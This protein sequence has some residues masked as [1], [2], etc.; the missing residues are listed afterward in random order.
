MRLGCML[1]IILIVLSACQAPNI[2][3]REI[4]MYDGGGDMVGTA[5]FIDQ[6][7]GV[8]IKVK[9]EG[10]DPGFHGAH[11][12]EFPICEGPDFTSAG[13]HFNPEGNKHGLMHPDGAHLGDLPNIEADDAG[14]AEAELLA[15]EA[16]LLEGKNSFLKGDG[17]SFIITANQDDGVSQPG[18]DSGKRL[19]CGKLTNE[20]KSEQK[21][22]SPTDPTEIEGEDEEE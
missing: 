22:N 11:V 16:T 1:G 15:P 19:L 12:H 6:E 21:E 5:T 20:Q 3:L 18:G 4:D 2:S 10:L 8:K 17:V 13:N 14:L 7:D 9:V